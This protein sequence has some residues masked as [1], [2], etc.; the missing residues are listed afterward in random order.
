MGK[1]WLASVVWLGIWWVVYVVVTPWGMWW[2]GG[3]AGILSGAC[4]AVLRNTLRLGRGMSTS[5]VYQEPQGIRI[6][7]VILE[8]EVR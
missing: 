4:Y 8:E 2:W 7:R 3:S 6:W 5:V 1:R